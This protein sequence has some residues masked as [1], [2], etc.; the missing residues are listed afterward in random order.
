MRRTFQALFLLFVFENTI[1]SVSNYF[2]LFRWSRRKQA[3][4]HVDIIYSRVFNKHEAGKRFKID[5]PE[6][7]HNFRH[8]RHCLPATRAIKR[9]GRVGSL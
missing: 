7:D 3:G 9:G 4:I 5:P 6:A 8:F 2:D 1:K